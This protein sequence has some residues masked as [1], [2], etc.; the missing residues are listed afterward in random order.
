MLA[1]CGIGTFVS[2][3]ELQLAVGQFE[4]GWLPAAV[5]EGI[6]GIIYKYLVAPCFTVVSASA[7]TDAK[8][9]VLCIRG[10]WSWIVANDNGAVGE[11]DEIWDAVWRIVAVWCNEF[12]CCPTLSFIR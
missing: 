8:M 10:G 5:L 3:V 9:S 6:V 11:L 12:G 4:E 2:K 1:S 7:Q